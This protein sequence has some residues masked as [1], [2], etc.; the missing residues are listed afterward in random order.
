MASNQC[1]GGQWDRS[2]CMRHNFHIQIPI[3]EIFVF[4]ENSRCVDQNPQVITFKQS[5]DPKKCCFMPET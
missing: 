5:F 3:E 2:T 1:H 4:L